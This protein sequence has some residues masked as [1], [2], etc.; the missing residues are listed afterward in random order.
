[1]ELSMIKAKVKPECAGQTH[2]SL[3]VLYPGEVYEVESITPEGPFAP[4]QEPPE[5]IVQ[6]EED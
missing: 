1:M 6:K 2:P 4:I 3:G 5:K